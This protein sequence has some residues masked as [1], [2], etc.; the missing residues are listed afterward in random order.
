MWQI[1][2]N[3]SKDYLKSWYN[4]TVINVEDGNILDTKHKESVEVTLIQK[5][6]DSRIVYS[7]MNLPIKYREV[8]YLFYFEELTIKE[9][10]KVIQVK[11]NTIKTRLR[12]AKELIKEELEGDV[13][14]R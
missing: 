4:K 14:G 12:R 9:I 13:N 2:I 1:A 5:D 11:H 10:E 6:D 7:V 8:I 3:H